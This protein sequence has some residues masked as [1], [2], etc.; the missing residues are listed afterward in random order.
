MEKAFA[1][2]NY[3]VGQVYGVDW[4]AAATT[5]SVAVFAMQIMGFTHPPGAAVALLSITDPKTHDLDW[6]LVPIV[7]INR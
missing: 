4:A 2:T 1:H 3:E 6:W 7:I 5:V